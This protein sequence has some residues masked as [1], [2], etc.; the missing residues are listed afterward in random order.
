MWTFMRSSAAVEGCSTRC[1]WDTLCSWGA[2]WRMVVCCWQTRDSLG[3][4]IFFDIDLKRFLCFHMCGGC[5][6]WWRSSDRLRSEFLLRR[7]RW[8][9]CFK[10]RKNCLIPH[11]CSYRTCNWYGFTWLKPLKWRTRCDLTRRR[12]FHSGIFL[13]RRFATW[14]RWN[15]SRSQIL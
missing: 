8:R 2:S 5:H 6:R 11:R 7:L 9:S 13:T 14:S 12:W 1:I 10:F 3:K 15:W 4:S